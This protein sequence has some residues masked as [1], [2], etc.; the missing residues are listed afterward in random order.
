MISSDV[1]FSAVLFR[2]AWLIAF[3]GSGTRIAVFFAGLGVQ[4]WFWK[5]EKTKTVVMPGGFYHLVLQQSPDGSIS[6]PQS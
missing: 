3:Q 4:D 6:T 2:F 1:F 5:S